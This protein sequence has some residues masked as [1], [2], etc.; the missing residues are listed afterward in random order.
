MMMQVNHVTAAMGVRT[1][2]TDHSLFEFKDAASIHLNKVLKWALSEIDA[3]IAVSH[4]NK[5]NLALRSR[6]DPSKI[7]VV[8]NAVDTSKFTPNPDAKDKNGK[9]NI[10]VICRMNFRK[11]VDLLVDIIPEIIRKYP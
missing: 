8:P 5:E 11:G 9:I 7:Y 2:F 6:I 4:T 3:A 1:V 10:V